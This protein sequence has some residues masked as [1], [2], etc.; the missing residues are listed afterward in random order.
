MKQIF[1]REPAAWIAAIQ[2]FLVLAVSFGWLSSLGLHSQADVALVVAVL[3]AAGGLY[4][5][6]GTS[7][8]MLAAIIEFFKAGLAL[9]AIYG[10]HISTEQ[11]GLVI[12]GINA[13][14]ALLVHRPQ[15][16][17]LTRGSFTTAA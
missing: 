11:T 15:T 5:A 3:A 13:I 16:S 2:S 8:T 14:F 6:W 17:P 7:E 1:G 10:L 9:G 4:L 12:A